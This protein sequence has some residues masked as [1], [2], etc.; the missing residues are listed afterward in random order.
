[1]KTREWFVESCISNPLSFSASYYH[2]AH[3]TIIERIALSFQEPLCFSRGPFAQ[4]GE[5]LNSSKTGK[6]SII[7]IFYYLL[8]FEHPLEHGKKLNI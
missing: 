5:R 3:R 8:E 6:F 1:V 4:W 7:G 2:L